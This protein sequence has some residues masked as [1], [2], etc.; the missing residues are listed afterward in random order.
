MHHR[1]G[2]VFCPSVG[3]RPPHTGITPNGSRRIVLNGKPRF[4]GR[5]ISG[6]VPRKTCPPGDMQNLHGGIEKCAISARQWAGFQNGTERRT[7]SLNIITHYAITYTRTLS[8]T[9]SVTWHSLCIERN[10]SSGQCSG[11]PANGPEIAEAD[12]DRNKEKR[13]MK[14]HI[15]TLV[16]A[17]VVMGTV[18]AFARGGGCGGCGGRGRSGEAARSGAWGNS[19]A[20]TSASACT[21]SDS[22]RRRPSRSGVGKHGEQ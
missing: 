11:K 2:A 16:A 3:A 8:M 1:T 7:E 22:N 6:N 21:P 20:G 13:T 4:Q 18:N 17:L 15:A 14:R 19:A 12:E 5:S 10:Q 9:V